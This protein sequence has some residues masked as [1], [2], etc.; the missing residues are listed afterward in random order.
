MQKTTFAQR[1]AAYLDQYKAANPQG[2][3]FIS[4]DPD[5]DGKKQA[6][7]VTDSGKVLSL[8]DALPI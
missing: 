4:V 3:Q 2:G 5:G 7:F 6:I 1:V 8:H